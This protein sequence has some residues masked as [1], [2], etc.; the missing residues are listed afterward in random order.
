MDRLRIV[1]M[2]TPDFAVP[3]LESLARGPHEVVAVVTQPD[4]PAGRGRAV[5]PPP[6][7]RAAERLR[8]P[9]ILQP[10]RVRGPS[11]A[12]FR[13]RLRAL[14]P[15]LAVVAAYGRILPK[16]VLETPRH[17]CINVHASLL[18]RWRGASP[19]QWAI[20]AGDQETGVCIMQMDEGLDTGPVFRCR[21]LPIAADETGGT[22]HDKLAALG[23]ELL[24]EVVDA[25]ARGA[26]TA[27][28]QS[29]AGATY[30]PRLTKADGRLEFSEPAQ[31]LERRV[32]AMQ[33]WPGAY[34]TVGGRSLKVLGA[35]PVPGRGAPGEVLEAAGD[36]LVVATG[37]GALRL[38]EVQPEGGRPMGV[39]AYLAGHPLRV[40]TRLGDSQENRDPSSGGK[41][42][43]EP[44]GTVS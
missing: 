21:R 11:G 8:I 13:D 19:I 28:P 17:G 34:T 24:P 16:E 42:P 22:L 25:I 31:A 1:F 27:T 29:E 3:A 23:A 15:D 6:V 5:R 30:A 32:R 43:A 38:L 4:R 36:R 37:D 44:E 33:P 35:E 14:K 18:P 20:L 41:A 7:K 10:E 40:G 39:R 2:G 12:A 26:A 9:E